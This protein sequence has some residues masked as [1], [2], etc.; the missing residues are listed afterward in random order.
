MTVTRPSSSVV[1]VSTVPHRHDLSMDHAVNQRIALVNF[2]IEELQ[3]PDIRSPILYCLFCEARST[4]LSSLPDQD[5]QQLSS[6][7]ASPVA[8]QLMGP[9]IV[10]STP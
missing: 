3:S 8:V 7:A 4:L 10:G 1:I 5:C 9:V 6:A 2:Y